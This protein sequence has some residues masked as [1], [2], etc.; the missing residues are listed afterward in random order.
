MSKKK[1]VTKTVVTEEI[2]TNEKTQIICILDR[3]GSMSSIIDDAR[4]GF[5]EFISKQ[6]E[7]ED[8]A[9]MT[10]AL[11]D[12]RYDL[13]Y[14]DVS[15]KEVEKINQNT[16][17]PRGMTALN[18]AI[19]KTINNVK[20]NHAKLKKKDRPDKVIVC[21]VTDG[22]E[23]ASMEYN[24]ESVKNLIKGCEKDNWSFV[25]LAA[26]QDA[27][28]VGQNYGFSVGNTMNFT[29]DSKGID[30]VY[31]TLTNTVSN[32]RSYSTTSGD[33][34]VNSNNLVGGNVAIEDEE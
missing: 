34:K 33:F 15:I 7:L 30:N 17:Y 6:K 9:S 11:F 8:E 27:F 21:I 5:N 26:N 3:S 25:Y 1:V 14:D 12:D 20:A 29:A 22:M 16:W 32:Y 23:N 28:A 2:I 31:A 13:L 19:G 18:D 24:S 4:G 10:V